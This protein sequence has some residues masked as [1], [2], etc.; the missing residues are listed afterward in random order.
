MNA[1]RVLLLF[2]LASFALAAQAKGQPKIDPSMRQ[3]V[4]RLHQ[5]FMSLKASNPDIAALRKKKLPASPVS[6]AQR[7][8]AILRE[9]NPELDEEQVQAK[10]AACQSEKQQEM[11]SQSAF[12]DMAGEFK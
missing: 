6:I 1:L 11:Q 10:I 2:A 5:K 4:N 12:P 8:Y 3:E 9:L 7:V